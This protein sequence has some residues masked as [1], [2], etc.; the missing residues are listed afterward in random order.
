MKFQSMVCSTTRRKK[1]LILFSLLISSLSIAY[2]CLNGESKSLK[3]G[4]FVYEDF[5]GNV[6]YG[7]DFFTDE[8]EFKSELRK[9]DSLF[10]VTK[11][12]DYL[13]DK[14]VL[15]IILGRYE[16][17]INLYLE[18]ERLEPN[19]YSTASNIGTAYELAG[20]NENALKWITRAIEIDSTS[21]NGSEWIHA[22]ILEAK[23]KGEQHVTTQ[24]LLNTD[25]GNKDIP[26]SQLTREEL[27]ELSNALYYQLNERVSFVKPKEKIVAQL[28]FDLGNIAFLRGNYNDALA[29]YEQAKEYGFGRGLI[30]TRM[31]LTNKFASPDLARLIEDHIIEIGVILM[32]VTFLGFVIYKRRSG[33]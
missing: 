32:I 28:Y 5:E 1:F 15:M 20:Q 17:A 7:H 18:I 33:R 21:H 25:F 10:D 8:D 9:L 30:E 4:V 11:D 3:S 27:E 19:R 13:S 29:D 31:M 6:P 23:I 12:L 2:G 16:D 26:V 24:F 22:R 14:G